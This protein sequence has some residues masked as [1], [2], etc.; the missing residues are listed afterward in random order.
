MSAERR[1]SPRYLVS[2]P[3][4]VTTAAGQSYVCEIL[5]LSE[6]GCRIRMA[7][8]VN[9]W[10]LVTL[11]TET[12]ETVARVIWSRGTEA[13]LWFPNTAQEPEPD[14]GFLRRMWTQLR[15]AA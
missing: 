1:Q 5:D 10:G 14:H 2:V 15:G 4:T 7:D 13:G 6:T 11:E 12:D 9:L 3:S 8:P